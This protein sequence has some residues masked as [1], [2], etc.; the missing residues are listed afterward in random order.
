MLNAEMKTVKNVL[1]RMFVTN[2]MEKKLFMKE[3]VWMNVR[4]GTTRMI[5][6]VIL[7]KIKKI[8]NH[9]TF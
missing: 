7:V 4:V 1:L 3:N 9:V 6:Y 5:M 8:A 2:A